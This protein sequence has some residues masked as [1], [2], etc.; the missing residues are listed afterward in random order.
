MTSFSKR[1]IIL[2]IDPKSRE[3]EHTVRWAISNLLD[4]NRDH[5]DLVFALD[6]DAD[7]TADAVSEAPAMYDY[8]YLNDI[9]QQVRAWRE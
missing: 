3:A 7:F 8:E 9:E 4:S 6:L 1:H 5:V 2:A